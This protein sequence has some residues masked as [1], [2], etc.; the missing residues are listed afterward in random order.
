[1]TTRRRYLMS[2][3]NGLRTTTRNFARRTAWFRR[4]I[5]LVVVVIVPGT[6]HH[7]SLAQEADSS[8]ALPPVLQSPRKP[9]DTLPFGLHCRQ[10][11]G[12][13]NTR[14]CQ[15]IAK[16]PIVATVSSA[17]EVSVAEDCS[18]VRDPE[19]GPYKSCNASGA[20]RFDTIDFL[21]NEPNARPGD[22]F[23]TSYSYES[24]TPEQKEGL[25]LRADRRYVIFAGAVHPNAHPPAEWYVVAACLLP[26]E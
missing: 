17:R 8:L 24:G 11:A 2:C 15:S 13:S 4:A 21:R 18:T 16:A 7:L 25:F 20:F 1:M 6:S 9:P 22:R 26:A 19:L 12:L 10:C 3:A 23:L 14:S 5:A